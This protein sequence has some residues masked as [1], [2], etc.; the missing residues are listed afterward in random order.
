MK[1]KVKTF[2]VLILL[3]LTMLLSFAFPR[4][5]Y[6]GTNFISELEIPYTFTEWQGQD[7]TKKLNINTANTN[8]NFINEAVANQ[9][10]NSKGESL[11]FI[12]LDAGNF[13]HPKVCF[14]GAGYKIKELDDT[15]FHTPDRSFKAHTLFT[16]RGNESSLSFYWIVIDKKV[17]HAWIEQKF[18]Q[19]YFSML[20]KQRVGLMVRLDVPAKEDNIEEAMLLAKRFVSDLGQTLKPEQAGYIWGGNRL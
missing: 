5:K 6:V 17:A 4:T 19:L 2:T 7:V 9:Y 11:L 3:S 15:E 14:T 8:F 12:I 18:K 10:I 16:E 20:N 1:D 13:H